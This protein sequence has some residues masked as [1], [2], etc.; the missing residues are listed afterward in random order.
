[1]TIKKENYQEP[2]FLKDPPP[3]PEQR[4]APALTAENV[5]DLLETRYGPGFAQWFVDQVRRRTAV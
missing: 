5:Y 2:P 4:L 1:M 3:R